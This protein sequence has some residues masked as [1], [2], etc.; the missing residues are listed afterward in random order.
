MKIVFMGTPD[1]AVPSLDILLKNGYDVV[2][3]I[4][5]TDKWGGRGNK[6]LLESDVKKYA[7]EKGLKILQPKNLKNPEFQAELRALNADLQIVV[8]FRMLPEAVWNM[9]PIGTMNLH[10]SLLPQYRGAAP[11]NWAVI[12]GEKETGVTTF[13]LQHEIDTG[14]LL[15]QAKTAIDE[16]ETTGE[17]YDRLKMIGADLML[18][19]VQ[20][21]EKGDYQLQAQDNSKVSHAPKIFHQDCNI[22]FN[23]TTEQVHNFVRGMSPYPTA[24]TTLDGEKLKVFRSSKEIIDHDKAVGTLFTDGKKFLKI[25]TQDGFLNLLDVQLTKRKRMDIKSFLNG[26]SIQNDQVVFN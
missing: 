26:Y 15:F 24:W 13:L 4:T 20:A 3:V 11:I 14:D 18:K 19:S 21:L 9:P 10:G 2:G 7:V 12:N 17:L 16:N 8:A 6:K 25:A 5:A 22:D 23:K 1:F